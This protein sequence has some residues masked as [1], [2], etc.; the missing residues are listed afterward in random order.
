ML[1]ILTK[2]S[3]PVSSLRTIRRS[4]ITYSKND[5]IFLHDTPGG[6]LASL[7]QDP[8]DMAI[9]TSETNKIDPE[10]FRPNK[11]FL[12]LLH[13]SIHDKI[14]QDF[15]YI[16]EAGVNADSYM[17]I[18]DF[19]EVPRFGR[20]PEVDSIFGYVRVSSDGK[21]IPK[22]YEANEMYRL[23]NGAGLV[24]L[25]NFLLEQLREAVKK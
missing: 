14:D 7:S 3:L 13:G 10:K 16:M 5:Q 15:T 2:L 19:R 20:T 1:R 17:P 6:V 24:K 23:C 21:I 8:K 9:G 25:S 12:E 18:Y 11:E 22:S 4:Y